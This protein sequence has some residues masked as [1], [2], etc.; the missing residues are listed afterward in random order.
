[1]R[2]LL[3]A[4][5]CV[6][7]SG[8]ARSIDDI[9]IACTSDDEC[10]NGSWCELGFDHVCRSFAEYAPPHLA[11]D[12]FDVGQ[13]LAPT[14][15]V[16]SRTISIGYLRLRNDGG[17]SCRVTVEV[18]GAPCLDADS[19]VRSDGVVLAVGESFK[20][21]FSVRPASGCPSPATLTVNATASERPFT[22]TAQIT[23]TP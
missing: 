4:M 14:I 17:V 12:G 20:A 6:P 22:F 16:P 21:D 1:M 3:V 8:C 9:G 18:E 2:G 11:F 10:P 13:E 19:L 23:I 15:I 5:L 7:A